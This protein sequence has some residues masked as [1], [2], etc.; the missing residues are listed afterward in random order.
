[1]RMGQPLSELADLR[2]AYVSLWAELAKDQTQIWRIKSELGDSDNV[3]QSVLL[4]VP[5]PR[6]KIME[7]VKIESEQLTMSQADH[8]KQKAFLR[9]AIKQ[10]EEQIA[11]LT[12]QQQKEDQGVKADAAELQKTIELYGKGSLPSPRV[13]DA[14]RGVLLSS[15]RLLQTT[16]QLLNVRRQQDDLQRQ[17]QRLDDL[18]KMDLLRQLQEANARASSL[19]ARLQGVAEKLQFTTTR[20]QLM[21]GDELKATIVVFR[22][23]R[24]RIT[25]DEDFELQPGDVVEVT[26]RPQNPSLGRQAGSSASGMISPAPTAIDAGDASFAANPGNQTA[27]DAARIANRILV[28]PAPSP[29]AEPHEGHQ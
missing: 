1:M 6:S 20:T 7:I 15:T 4:D 9:Y 27:A 26:L 19:R 12:D 8:E 23:A 25:A 22:K 3:D 14:R 28:R 10:G 13:I 29:R 21:S 18:R 11:I 24:E 5:L 17:I 16:A 2:S